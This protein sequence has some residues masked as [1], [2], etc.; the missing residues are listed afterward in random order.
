[1]LIIMVIIDL[2]LLRCE[3]VHMVGEQINSSNVSWVAKKQPDLIIT[4]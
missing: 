1:M 3:F 2:P 4:K